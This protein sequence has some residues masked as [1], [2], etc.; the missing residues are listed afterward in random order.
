MR[1][2]IFVLLILPT[3]IIAQK[4]YAPMGAVWTYEGHEIDCQGNHK[5][6][7]VEREVDIDGK[8]CSVIYNYNSS[9]IDPIFVKSSD[10]LIVWEN[11]N[12][13]YFL[14]DSTFYLLYDFNAEIGDTVIFYDPINRGN[15]SST[16][17][18]NPVN[19]PTE[20]IAYI[21]EVEIREIESQERK[22]FTADTFTD[23]FLFPSPVIYIENIGST[24]QG[25]SGDYFFYVADGCFGGLQCYENENIEYV[26]DRQ[27]ET[28]PP[29]CNLKSGQ[30]DI[31]WDIGTKWTYELRPNERITSFVTN[32]IVDTVTMDG[33]KLY[34]VDSN[35]TFTGIRY[36]HYIDGRVYNYD[37]NNQILQLL[38]DFD[39][40]D[41]YMTDY[42]P[43]CD[44]EFDYDSLVSQSY[45]IRIDSVVNY[46]MPDGSIRKMQYTNNQ[47][48]RPVLSNIGFFEGY[49]HNTHDWELGALICGEQGNYIGQL[50]C[51]ENDTLQY[52]F[53]DYPCDTIWGLSNVDDIKDYHLLTVY[54]NPTVDILQVVLPDSGRYRYRISDISGSTILV[55]NTDFVSHLDMDISLLESGMYLI[56]LRTEKLNY[57]AKFV[58]TE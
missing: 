38:Y 23:S 8:D 39:A 2:I 44:P 19:G 52:N 25:I 54:P 31:V 7:I 1:I 40:T 4:Q 58:K 22:F 13:V 57:V 32:E 42:R 48:T 30:S 51:F 15:F 10:S 56:T 21:T 28:P 29:G 20:S 45:T 47:E 16:F 18:L 53:N 41:R 6:Y 5:Q 3:V 49:T 24:D 46:V 36:F 43:I 50:R 27:L 17:N 9:D 14:E 12:Q 35:P 11:M 26:T 34:V 33:L 55:G 37:P